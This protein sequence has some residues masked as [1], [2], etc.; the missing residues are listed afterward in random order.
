MAAARTADDRL[1]SRKVGRSEV[2][3][4]TPSLRLSVSP[5]LRLSVS[6]SLRPA[7]SIAELLI[8]LIVLG[9]GL[10]FI[11]AAIPVGVRY[12]E[13]TLNLTL[14][15]AAATNAMEQ[16]ELALATSTSLVNVDVAGVSPADARSD[17]IFRPR[18]GQIGAAVGTP[19]DVVI[20]QA[21]DAYEPLVKVRPLV[22]NNFQRTNNNP[23]W[24][25][26]V[27]PAESIITEYLIAVGFKFDMSN[28]IREVDV[29][30]GYNPPIGL[31][32]GP[33]LPAAARVFPPMDATTRFKVADFLNGVQGQEPYRR[34]EPR[35]GTDN[36][37]PQLG[38]SDF[39]QIEAKRVAARRVSWTAFY[40]RISYD[41]A[42]PG[43]DGVMSG[44]PPSGDDVLVPGD[45]LLY[46][47]IIVVTAR[48]SEQH[49]FAVQDLSNGA[50]FGRFIT[51]RATLPNSTL[52]DDFG[53]D[54]L[55]PVPWLVM[56]DD[57]AGPLPLPLLNQGGA[58]NFDPDCT[59]NP[60]RTPE[61]DF[62][63]RPTLTF[64]VSQTLGSMLP[65]GSIFIP[66][67]NDARTNCAD[68]ASGFVPHAPESLPIY[69]VV[70][71]PDP[72]TVIVKNNGF[73][74]WVAS[75]NPQD[76]MAWPV[77]VIP[78]AF[79]SRGMNAD[80]VNSQPVFENQSP[81]LTVLRKVVRLP[82]SK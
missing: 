48:P 15:D 69:E 34:Y 45:P 71:R 50:G 5:S 29:P 7:F 9:I 8:A 73:Y 66:A 58:N 61:L 62:I 55:C 76:T 17:R 63:D 4:S 31:E 77:W 39:E 27:D 67:L 41:R 23:P 65:V 19:P 81:I 32:D 37:P 49:R 60:Q 28:P 24:E 79:A 72:R 1:E 18:N 16:V 57:S 6:P 42:E 38:D 47:I 10:L 13:Q 20:N 78:P 56:F 22:L 30:F 26:T 46:E 44:L 35:Y 68:R 2:R 33:L 36:S 74:P 43:P 40:R 82:E 80:R 64:K 75:N 59:V 12:T 54:V 3:D 21:N 25:E 53:A 51:P 11:A 70:Q 52:A 14:G